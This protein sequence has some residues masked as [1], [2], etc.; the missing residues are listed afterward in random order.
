MNSRHKRNRLYS[1]LN[2][3]DER[4]IY[5]YLEYGPDGLREK[6]GVESDY[7]WEVIFDYLVFEK[8]VVKYCARNSSAYI[9]DLFAEHG[10]LAIRRAFNLMDEK[11]EDV[12]EYLMDYIGVSRGAIYEYVTENALKY[13]DK[14]YNGQGMSLRAELC[15]QKTKYDYVWNEILDILLHAVSTNAFTHSAFEHGL[16]LFSKLYNQGRVQRSLRSSQFK[17]VEG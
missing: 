14:I 11:Y 2:K 9:H 7:L 15:L 16:G 8:E 3:Y 1:M 12:W 13:R 10:P 4:L 17:K 6:L 5:N